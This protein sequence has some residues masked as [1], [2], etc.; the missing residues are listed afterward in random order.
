MNTSV[1]SCNEIAVL[2]RTPNSRP[3]TGQS[4][5]CLDPPASFLA[6]WSVAEAIASYKYHRN[7]FS[8]KE[9]DEEKKY[10]Y[11]YIL[12]DVSLFVVPDSP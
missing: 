10:I 7:I 12:P 11:I 9:T 1:A 5:S 2:D 3:I 8:H 6:K 4:C